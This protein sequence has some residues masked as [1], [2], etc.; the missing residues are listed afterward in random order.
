MSTKFF[1]PRGYF[2]NSSNIMG[3]KYYD[4]SKVYY[5]LIGNYDSF[6]RRKF[7]LYVDNYSVEI[8]MDNIYPEGGEN[9]FKLTGIGTLEI[10]SGCPPTD[11]SRFLVYELT[12]IK[13]P[14]PANIFCSIKC[15]AG[16]I[17]NLSKILFIIDIHHII[18]AHYIRNAI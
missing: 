13:C 9:I 5:S 8:M 1:D 11:I 17:I 2:A 14:F 4:I 3:D 16:Q 7:K 6:N 12:A 15:W 18:P 10:F